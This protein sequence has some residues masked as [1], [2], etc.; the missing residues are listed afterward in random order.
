MDVKFCGVNF[1]HKAGEFCPRNV[2][3]Y[4]FISFFRTDFLYEHDGEL[5]CGKAGDVLIIPRGEPVYHGPMPDA[6]SGFKNDWL[7][8][9]G[10]DFLDFLEEYPLPIG[11]PF[12]VNGRHILAH[13]IE[14]IKSEQAHLSRGYRDMC[15]LYI[16]EAMIEL[17]R[18]Y[19][20]G[21]KR[22]SKSK[23]EALRAELSANPSHA[24]TLESMAKFCGYSESRFSAIYRE[25]YGISP[26]ADLINIRLESAKLMLSYSN[27]GVSEIAEAVGFS[28]VY[29]FSKYFKK[30]TGKSPSEYKSANL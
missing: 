22:N 17:H 13:C 3:R 20:G 7:Y 30:N 15:E 12:K 28:S 5:L 9:D 26:M 1:F 19:I 18:A 27:L 16:K 29:Y 21:G 8:I 23:T 14:K 24:W 10:D 2:L 6:E 4:H 11:K 25:I